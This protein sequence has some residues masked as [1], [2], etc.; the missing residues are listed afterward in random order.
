VVHAGY[1]AR[2]YH[3]HSTAHSFS[4]LGADAGPVVPSNRS[5]D[6]LSGC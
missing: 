4:R 6:L 3:P 1:R 5:E 2:R